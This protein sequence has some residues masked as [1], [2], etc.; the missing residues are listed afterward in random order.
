MAAQASVL[1][2]DAK[3]RDT[4]LS[5]VRKNTSSSEAYSSGYILWWISVSFSLSC[6]QPRNHTDTGNTGG[7]IHKL[8]PERSP[9]KARIPEAGNTKS[10]VERLA[11]GNKYS[12]HSKNSFSCFSRNQ[13]RSNAIPS[14]RTIAYKPT[15]TDPFIPFR[16]E[17]R[18]SRGNICY[19][20]GIPTHAF[21]GIK[22]VP[23][24]SPTS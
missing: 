20:P 11:R 8:T 3:N 19:I 9:K 16:I 1:R 17:E 13:H 10:G 15:S 5:F 22:T 24:Q 12:L 2:A 18:F 6:R 7:I 14:H 4:V 23:I 21:P